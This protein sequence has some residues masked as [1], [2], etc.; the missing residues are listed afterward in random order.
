MCVRVVLP[1]QSGAPVCVQAFGCGN[2]WSLFRTIWPARRP[3]DSLFC[4][5][6]LRVLVSICCR[7]STFSPFIF[8]RGHRYRVLIFAPVSGSVSIF[9]NDLLAGVSWIAVSRRFVPVVMF[10][11]RLVEV[12][13]YVAKSS[14]RRFCVGPRCFEPLPAICRID[15]RFCS[16][17][18]QARSKR[19]PIP[20]DTILVNVRAVQIERKDAPAGSVGGVRCGRCR[21]ACR[22][23][24]AVVSGVNVLRRGNRFAFRSMVGS[25]LSRWSR[26]L[27]RPDTASWRGRSVAGR[28]GLL[29]P[30]RPG[31]S[32]ARCL[33]RSR[34][35]SLISGA[36]WSRLRRGVCRGRG[37]TLSGR[38]IDPEFASTGRACLCR[39]VAVTGEI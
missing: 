30:V 35:Y 39:P 32:P 38:L 21:A 5:R 2:S 24:G 31:R 23:S 11:I 15:K 36:S 1:A 22:V 6:C 25:T 26:Y 9:Y 16:S 19:Q 27:C 8:R 12:K 29:S 4:S 17:R 10:D 14:R 7:A 3:R 13:V 20:K 33:S 18:C 34:W 28:G 37:G